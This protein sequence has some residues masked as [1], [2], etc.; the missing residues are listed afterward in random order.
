[1][2]QRLVWVGARALVGFLLVSLW[3]G[4]GDDDDD[5]SDASVASDGAVADS[6]EP[7][8][9]G[10]ATGQVER[11]RYLVNHVAVCVDCHT[12][13]TPEG[14]L[15]EDKLLSGVDCFLDVDPADD[16][17]CLATPNL[18]NHSTGLMSRSDA[19]IK[20]MF[21]EGI[22]V[23]K[24]D[25]AMNPVMPYWSFGNMRDEDADAIVA[26]L[27][28]VPGVDHMV[29]KSQPPFDEAP[30]APAVRVDLEMVP[31]PSESYSNL[32]A[33]E[34]GR[35]LA[36]QAGVCLECHTPANEPGPLPPRMLDK[37]FQGGEEF[38]A[39]ALGLPSPPF[40]EVI[41]SANIT[42]HDDTG[43]G[44]WTVSDVVTVLK[45]GKS[46]DGSGICPPM[47]AGPMGAFGG[48]TD[49][50]ATD[51]AHFLLS[52]PG[53]EADEPGQCEAPMPPSDA[54]GGM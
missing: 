35:Y 27:R 17:G 40:P 25:E 39:A 19:E 36:A 21:L 14:A 31:K 34:R 16:A 47:P 52:I 26:Y 13:R 8:D 23:H 30:P 44:G 18:T 49:D 15:D 37:A 6:G 50:D 33:A 41:Y 4:C 43:I 45:E 11:G 9:A 54:D 10:D 12:P 53:V 2:S 42:P 29:A 48:L 5:T 46:K 51:I 20:S 1:M 32:A 24:D 38:P 7:A 3:V 22:R 28:T